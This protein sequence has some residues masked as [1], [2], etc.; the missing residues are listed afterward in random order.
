MKLSPNNNE[1]KI[2]FDRATQQYYIVWE[3]SVIGLGQTKRKALEDLRVAA[4]F[5]VDSLIDQ[6]LRH[7][8]ETVSTATV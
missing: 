4:H 5:G 2:E 1:I 7:I 8:N 6:K 3:L